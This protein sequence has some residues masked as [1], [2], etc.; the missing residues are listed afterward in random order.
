MKNC[1]PSDETV[2]TSRWLRVRDVAAMLS[3]SERFVYAAIERRDLPAVRWGRAVRI[4]RDA[5]EQ[6][7]ADKEAQAKDKNSNDYGSKARAI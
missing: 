7:L 6:W 1:F 5:F 4:P 3:V 2:D